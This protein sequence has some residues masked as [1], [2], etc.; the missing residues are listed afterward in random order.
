MISLAGTIRTE[1]V[2]KVNNAKKYII[3]PVFFILSLLTPSLINAL[4]FQDMTLS[5]DDRFL[6]RL[7]FEDQNALFVSNLESM[8]LKQLTAYPE[9]IYLVDN[10]RTILILNRFGLSKIPITGGL[11]EPVQGYPSF[12]DGSQPLR[13]RLQDIAASADGRWVLFIEPVSPGFGNLILID[14][15][16]GVKRTVSERIEMPGTDFPVKWSSDSRFFIYSKSGRIFYFPIINN[17]PSLVDERFRLI[18]SGTINSVFWGR[19]G[20]FFYLTGNTLYRIINPELLTRTMY[21]DFLSIG[22]VVA[23][24]PVDFDPFFDMYWIAPDSGTTSAGRRSSDARSGSILINKGGRGFFL[25]MPGRSGSPVLPHVTLPYGARNFNVLW[26]SSGEITVTYMVGNETRAHRFRISGDS[27]TVLEHDSVPVSSAGILSPDE[28]KAAFWG[29]D[30]L[31]LW[32]YTNWQL[33]YRLNRDAV[34]SCAWI[35]NRQLLTGNSR[36]IEDINISS[37]TYPRR[38]ICLSGVEEIGFEEAGTRVMARMGTAWFATDERNAWASVTNVRVRPITFSSERFRVFLETQFSGPYANIPMVRNLRST[39]TVPLLA[40]LES[41]RGRPPAV[42]IYPSEPQIQTALC[43]DLYDDD[44]GLAQ[45]LAALGRFNIKATFFMNGEFIRRNPHAV[46]A[47]MEAGHEAASLFYA[48]IDL[49]DTRYRITREFITQGLARNEDEFNRV[50]GRELSVLWH[51]PFYRSSALI[52]TAASSAGYV[53]IARTIDPGDY[54]SREDALRLNLRLASP[55][56]MIDQI[57]QRR[58]PNAVIPVRL[59]LLQGGRDDYLFRHIEVLIDALLRSGCGIVKV[60]AA[61]RR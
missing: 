2:Q 33:I 36:F 16:N 15:S 17:L 39:N 3:L 29:T 25:F 44:T 28:T 12:V 24:L 54:L 27:I 41:A 51:P 11:P 5:N 46:S 43:F 22:E 35:N 48:P 52:N 9:K 4:E 31:E 47:V 19:Q 10:G 18:G 49:S 20:D 26:P 61:I 50:T 34:L 53:N 21:G 14:L 6:F 59:G 8:S 38:R 7:D 30:G 58:E 23:V 37:L 32:D 42:N 60:S 57:I 45:V 13:G 1:K 40:G 55:A 56:E